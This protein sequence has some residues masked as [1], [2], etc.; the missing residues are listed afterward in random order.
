MVAVIPDRREV[1]IGKI[2]VQGQPK[3]RVR[4]NPSQ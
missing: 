3:Q 4:E 2:I 1:E